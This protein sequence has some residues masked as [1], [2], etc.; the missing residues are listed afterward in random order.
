MAKEGGAADGGSDDDDPTAADITRFMRARQHLTARCSAVPFAAKGLRQPDRS[1]RRAAKC[2]L[3]RDGTLTSPSGRVLGTIR[4]EDDMVE[5][6]CGAAAITTCA[7]LLLCAGIVA[8]PAIPATAFS[9]QEPGRAPATVAPNELP[10]GEALTFPAGYREWVFL[11]AGLGMNYGPNAPA[12]GRPQ[13]F[14]NVF[15]NPSSYQA[16]VKTG[17]W[18]DQTTFVLEI[19]GAATEGSINRSGQYQ[20]DIRAIEVNRKDGRVP[21]GWAFYD[22]GRNTTPAARLPPTATC[23]SCHAANAAV[24]HTFVQ[25][26]PDLMA[27]AKRLGTVKADFIP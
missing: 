21:G 2:W 19:R 7:T 18:P 23:Y 15:V 25:F 26:Y 12:A 17:A 24:E 22:F 1:I 4:T 14:T 9:L 3:Q 5:C 10:V 27:I 13:N 8:T 6:R 16:F 20:T 11:S